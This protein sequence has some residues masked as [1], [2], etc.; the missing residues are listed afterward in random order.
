MGVKGRALRASGP[1]ETVHLAQHT[2]DAVLAAIPA[3]DAAL[4][5]LGPR[6]RTLSRFLVVDVIMPL[7]FIDES[8]LRMRGGL[9][10]SSW[11]ETEARAFAPGGELR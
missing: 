10:R 6:G 8:E 7:R 4:E 3:S 1:H 5:R 11:Y 2:R 9:R